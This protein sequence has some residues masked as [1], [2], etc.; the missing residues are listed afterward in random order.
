MIYDAIDDALDRRA[1]QRQGRPDILQHRFRRRPFL[2]RSAVSFRPGAGEH[3]VYWLRVSCFG[4][5][6]ERERSV[7]GAGLRCR[8]DGFVTIMGWKVNFHH[9]DGARNHGTAGAITFRA[10]LMVRC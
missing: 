5:P 1:R 7:E 2:H 8:C 10:Q 6:R 4:G 3:A 9:S